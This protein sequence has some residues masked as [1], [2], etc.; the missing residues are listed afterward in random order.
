MSRIAEAQCHV[1][2]FPRAS[3]PVS[4]GASD[5]IIVLNT[6]AHGALQRAGRGEFPL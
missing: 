3:P 6:P 4:L 2:L 5:S 1:M